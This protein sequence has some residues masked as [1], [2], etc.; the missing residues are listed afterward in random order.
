[1]VRSYVTRNLLVPTKLSFPCAKSGIS[2][3]NPILF[4][5]EILFA[6]YSTVIRERLAFGKQRSNFSKRDTTHPSVGISQDV[7]FA[8]LR[9]AASRNACDCKTRGAYRRYVATH[10]IHD[11]TCQGTIDSEK[12]DTSG[13]FR[14]RFNPLEA[15][16]Y[17]HC[18][19]PAAYAEM[20]VA[21]CAAIA[22]LAVSGGAGDILC[23]SAARRSPASFR[24]TLF[25]AVVPGVTSI[26]SPREEISSQKSNGNFNNLRTHNGPGRLR[27][28]FQALSYVALCKKKKIYQRQNS[29]SFEISLLRREFADTDRVQFAVSRLSRLATR[30][31]IIPH[32][33]SAARI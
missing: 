32:R 16:V 29:R 23:D 26:A 18:A 31:I 15:A 9:D 22:S 3:H 20:H 2:Y 8:F 7:F 28:I 27:D 30:E 12:P 13:I 25:P 10:R 6:R 11:R 19:C 17:R 5:R 14:R 21:G 1:M 4:A 24:G 33:L